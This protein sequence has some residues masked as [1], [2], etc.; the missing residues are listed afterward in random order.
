MPT[1]LANIDRWYGT[2]GSTRAYLDEWRRILAQPVEL[3]MAA[4]VE[5][6]EEMTALRQSTPFSGILT[7][8]E[9]WAV[10]RQ[11]QEDRS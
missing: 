9:R 6:S 7:P 3:V 10:Y 11:F 2:A 1:A 8:Q 4:M 5:D